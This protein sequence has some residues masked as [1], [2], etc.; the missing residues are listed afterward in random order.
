MVD[1]LQ[2]HD[3]YC[4]AP[5][6]H[7]HSLQAQIENKMSTIDNVI[8]ML[9]NI[10][11]KDAPEPPPPG[12][13][14]DMLMGGESKKRKKEGGS[15]KRRKKSVSSDNHSS[16][17]SS[18]DEDSESEKLKTK[19]IESMKQRSRAKEEAAV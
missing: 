5:H 2:Y 18:N 9:T 13:E 12:H 19:V 10:I 16:G 7:S 14:E 15:K 11:G 17:Q 1:P 4:N 3:Y 8:E 6:S